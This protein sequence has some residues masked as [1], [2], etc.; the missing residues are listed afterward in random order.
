VELDKSIILLYNIVMKV[1]ELIQKYFEAIFNQ[2]PE[3]VAKLYK[4]IT[5][6]S[7]KGKKTH[8]VK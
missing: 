4:K 5:K 3:R 6:K 8:R 2:N 1:K 7:L